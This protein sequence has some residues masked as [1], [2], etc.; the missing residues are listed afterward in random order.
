VTWIRS[1]EWSKPCER[2]SSIIKDSIVPGHCPG[3]KNKFMKQSTLSGEMPRRSNLLNFL[4]QK[5]NIIIEIVSALFVLLFLYTAITKSFEID[6]TVNVIKKTPFIAS[7]AE[8]IAWV[9]V[10][11]EYI[12]SI[13]LFMPRTRKTGL[14]FALGL[15]T[16]FTLYIG[17]MKLF[18]PKLP[19]S[20]GGVISKLTWNQHLL[21]NLLF[22][23]LAITAILLFKSYRTSESR[24][25]ETRPIVFT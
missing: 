25:I 12:V 20:C 8:P 22:I 13:M 3:F 18:I 2:S 6:K 19:C 16:T 4:I 1:Q 23:F 5:R 7:Y 24:N 15:M 10:L 14:Y 9:V 17:Y 11:T 21:F